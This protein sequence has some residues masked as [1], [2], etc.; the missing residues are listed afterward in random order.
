MIPLHERWVVYG[1]S[2]TVCLACFLLVEGRSLQLSYFVLLLVLSVQAELKYVIL[3]LGVS[4]YN[5]TG[6]H[7]KAPH[8][9]ATITHVFIIWPTLSWFS[10]EIAEG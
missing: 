6:V 7:A 9:K 5:L 8:S 1:Y 2:E 10:A 4:P 3:K